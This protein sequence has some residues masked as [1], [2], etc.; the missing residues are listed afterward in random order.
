MSTYKLKYFAVI[1]LAFFISADGLTIKIFRNWQIS[2]LLTICLF[3]LLLINFFK[4]RGK[5]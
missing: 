2:Q 4:K 5:S 1:I 3:S